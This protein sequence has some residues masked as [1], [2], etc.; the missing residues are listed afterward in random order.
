MKII[1]VAAVV[2]H[3][4]TIAIG[5][6]IVNTLVAVHTIVVA[7]MN[8]HWRFI[9]CVSYYCLRDHPNVP[10]IGSKLGA[11]PVFSFSFLSSSCEYQSTIYYGTP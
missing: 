4:T 8:V 7:A 2:E 10:F 9:L 11:E 5:I 6:T 3:T 1:C